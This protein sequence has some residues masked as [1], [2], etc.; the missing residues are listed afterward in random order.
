MVV[1]EPKKLKMF[2]LAE[3]MYRKEVVCGD[4]LLVTWNW[5]LPNAEAKMHKHDCEQV[6]YLL[7]GA[8]EVTINDKTEVA[9]AEAAIFIPSGVLHSARVVGEEPLIS[10]DIY[11]P[12]LRKVIH[13][14]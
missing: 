9:E 2:K 10:I 11:A 5:A 14:E 3:G 12:P 8:L 6:V 4:H 7:R 1:I 13:Q